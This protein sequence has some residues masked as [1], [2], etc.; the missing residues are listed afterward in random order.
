MTATEWLIEQLIPEDQHEGIMDI[1]E[2]A[3]ER[4]KQQIIDAA[5]LKK[6]DRWYDAKLYNNCGEKYYAETYGSKGSETTS[7]QTTSD[8]WK[9]YQDWLNEVP[10]L[11]DEEIEK[12]GWKYCYENKISLKN[13]VP[14]IN[15]CEWYREQ[16][17]TKQ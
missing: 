12:E 7:S 5:N 8:K 14:W 2:D 17:K 9:E 13:I 4:E 11:S 3:K 1:I 16:L 10:E 6:E 15:A